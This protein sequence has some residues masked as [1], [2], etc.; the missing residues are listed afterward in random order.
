VDLL[1]IARRELAPRGFFGGAKPDTLFVESNDL[2]A[3]L[4]KLPWVDLDDER[5]YRD[6]T[7]PSSAIVDRVKRLRG[8]TSAPE[9][10][11]VDRILD[12]EWVDEERG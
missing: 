1:V 5:R 10:I 6:V 2:D 4:T 8:G 12:R 9:M 11:S 7:D 3:L